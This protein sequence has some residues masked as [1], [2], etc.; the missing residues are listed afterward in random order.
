MKQPGSGVRRSLS[1]ENEWRATTTDEVDDFEAVSVFQICCGPEIAGD[2]V[3]IELYGDAV[4]L[5]TEAFDQCC[6]GEGSRGVVEG[7]IFAID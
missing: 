1:G 4:G 6:Q 7:A 2:D 3:A 5:H